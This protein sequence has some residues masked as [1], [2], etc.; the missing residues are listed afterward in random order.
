MKIPTILQIALETI[1]VG[2][3]SMTIIYFTLSLLEKTLDRNK[4]GKSND[5]SA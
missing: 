4:G 3:A 2:T 1:L 5:D